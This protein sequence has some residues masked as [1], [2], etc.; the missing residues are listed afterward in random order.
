MSTRFHWPSV[1][2]T[3]WN[4]HRVSPG[5][6]QHL[7]RPCLH[8]TSVMMWPSVDRKQRVPAIYTMTRS[9]CLSTNTEERPLLTLEA[10]VTR[11]VLPEHLSEFLPESLGP[12]Q[13][14]TVMSQPQEPGL[15][16][17]LAESLCLCDRGK[18]YAQCESQVGRGWQVQEEWE[19]MA[20]PCI[21][22]PHQHHTPGLFL[23]EK[24][25][26]QLRKPL[27][28]HFCARNLAIDITH[29]IS[30]LQRALGLWPGLQ[31]WLPWH[32]SLCS[33]GHSDILRC[34]FS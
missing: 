4:P 9:P 18:A 24:G 11:V 32:F 16:A 17:S 5:S 1:G 14:P 8:T 6:E 31:Q 13:K 10:N 22:F 19:H 27:T 21:G 33:Y 34:M 15:C 7:R 29:G 26:N 12:T 28:M 23:P 25:Q 3:N 30:Y 20:G 2:T